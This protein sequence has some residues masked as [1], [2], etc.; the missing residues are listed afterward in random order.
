MWSRENCGVVLQEHSELLGDAIEHCVRPRSV[1]Y[2]EIL[3]HIVQASQDIIVDDFELPSV[4]RWVE[5]VNQCI[6]RELLET[7]CDG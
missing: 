1:I 6:A 3:D 2:R 5:L 4:D 7:L